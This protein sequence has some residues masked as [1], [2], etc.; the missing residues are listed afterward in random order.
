MSDSDSRQEQ[1]EDPQRAD[2]DTADSGILRARDPWITRISRLGWGDIDSDSEDVM[3]RSEQ[4][5]RDARRSRLLAAVSRPVRR[6]PERRM[7]VL[8][9]A[10]ASFAV[11]FALREVSAGTGDAI[12][13][14]Y[15]IPVALVSLELGLRAGVLSA[16]VAVGAVAVWMASAGYVLDG[17]ALIVRSA[18]FVS[19]AAIA[20]RFSDRM[21][22][23]SRREERLLRSGLDL[24]HINDVG[25]LAWVLAEHV[26][27]CTEAASVRVELQDVPAVWIGEQEGETMR[28]PIVSR[29]T[30]IGVLTVSAG[31]ARRF[32]PED[33]LMVET[34]ALQAAVACENQR[35]LSV[36]REQAVLHGE[37]ERMR[38][39]LGDQLR[40]ASHV[41]ERHE[42]E[43][44]GIA[45]QLHEE[46]AQAMAAAL[47]TVAS[48]ERGVGAEVTKTQ[49]EDVRSHMRSC[50]VDLR[51]IAGSLRPS[52]LDEMGLASA[53]QLISEAEAEAGRRV[54]FTVDGLPERMPR[55][56]ETSTYR[57]IEAL[58]DAMV[59]ASSIEAGLQMGKESLRILLEARMPSEDAVAQARQAG[60]PSDGAA[61]P[62]SGDAITGAWQ[63]GDLAEPALPSG[64][65]RASLLPSGDLLEPALPSGGERA[66]LLPSGDLAE[67]A[68]PTGGSEHG[69]Q[70]LLHREL[71]S[72]RAH[73]ELIG[74]SL[75]VSPRE[76]DG[77]SI[78]AE[79]PMALEGGAA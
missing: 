27:L 32:D 54:S 28:V 64:G 38:R 33:R 39:R 73:V 11:I 59:S 53:L 12:S 19:V 40:N 70:R 67:P 60:L 13:L 34:V 25:S 78:V 44:R 55:E 69:P 74:G 56:L 15:V 42:S 48:L 43:R 6:G 17:L 22:V 9:A 71:M 14:L 57:V 24:A 72:A 20:G 4:A 66:S 2:R 75:H 8:G 3:S 18:I 63:P 26:Q 51:R 65:E 37:M 5:G 68:L 61:G 10:A 52:V 49:L 30:P 23:H 47:I 58:L 16:V 21:R 36:E 1:A 46:A 7:V 29:G 76:E 50:I 41:L 79:I 45:R 31:A 77:V 62:A 35:L